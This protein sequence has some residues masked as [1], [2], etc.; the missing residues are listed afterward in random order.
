MK[1]KIKISHKILFALVVPVLIASITMLF[2]TQWSLRSGFKNYVANSEIEKMSVYIDGIVTV[3]KK[4]GGLGDLKDNR[5]RWRHVLISSEGS[6]LD[7]D[8]P[9]EF[10]K[11]WEL[12]KADQFMK[13]RRP[14]PEHDHMFSNHH[15]QKPP[16]YKE[17]FPPEFN[18]KDMHNMSHKPKFGD[19]KKFDGFFMLSRLTLYDKNKK[20]VVGEKQTTPIF[21]EIKVEQSIIGYLGLEPSNRIIKEDDIHF[22]N[23]QYISLLIIFGLIL[24]FAI[25]I[26]VI[27]SKHITKPLAIFTN[28]IRNLAIGDYSQRIELNSKDELE[29]LASD[30]NH[31]ART[32]EKNEKSRQ[33]WVAGISHELRTPIAILRGEIEAIQDRVRSA[34]DETIESLYSEVISLNSIVDDLYTLSLSDIGEL[35]YQM[36]TISPIM[37]LSNLLEAYKERISESGIILYCKFPEES[38]V[39]IYGDA[40][41]VKQLFKNIIENSIKYTLSPGKLLIAADISEGGIEI[42]FSD[43]QPS[44][45]EGSFEKIFE[46][47]HREKIFDISED[48]YG[49][50]LGLAICKNIVEAHNGNIRA[51]KSAL[52]GLQIK[53]TFETIAV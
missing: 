6:A 49:N 27:I 8:A 26:A 19:F 2:L 15:P 47:F 42:S 22:L 52:G 30:I 35:Q 51:A 39:N 13:G 9:E 17:G 43:S 46:R 12:E 41:R 28:S 40:L 32:L 21:K 38:V 1:I 31:L 23:K 18:E 33:Y 25:V 50:G 53:I 44:V 11:I 36:T 45:N 5:H 34:T 3:Y 48:C 4:R 24:L 37:I 7:M 20:I 16:F 14:P 29:L 10:P